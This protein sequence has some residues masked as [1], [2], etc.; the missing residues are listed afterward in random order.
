MA[1][2]QSLI[3]N[4]QSNPTLCYICEST[5]GGVRKHLR[6]LLRVFV[7]PEEKLNVRGIFGDRGEPGFRDELAAFKAKFPAFDYTLVPQ[8]QRAIGIRD[9]SA[10]SH[11][12]EL[13]RAYK[14]NII[15]THGTKAGIIGREAA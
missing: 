3:V 5:Q 8:F 2:P 12:K 15:H 10:Y 9:M 4:P 14:P 6:E 11:V 13:L 7:R 1:N